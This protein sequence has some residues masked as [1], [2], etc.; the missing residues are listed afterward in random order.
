LIGDGVMRPSM[1]S[2]RGMVGQALLCPTIPRLDFEAG[3]SMCDP[4][5]K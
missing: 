2:N 5:A 1:D 3:A 4:T